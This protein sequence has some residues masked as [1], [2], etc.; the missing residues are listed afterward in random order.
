MLKMVISITYFSGQPNSEIQARNDKTI[1]VYSIEEIELIR[2]ASRIGRLA[3][4]AG[5]WAAKVG[6][7]TDYIDEVVH[8]VII[9]NDAYPSPLNYYN[10]PKSVCTSVNEVICHGIPD[11]RPLQDGDILNIDVSVYKGGVH[12]DL[13]ETFLIGNVAESAKHLV[14]NAYIALKKSIESCKP[15][16]MY[17]DIG[18]VISKHCNNESL[19]VVKSYCGHGVG[20]MFHCAPQVPHYAKNKAVGFMKP[21]HIFTIEPM[22]NQGDWR[23]TMWKD[24][25]TAVR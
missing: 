16:S 24:N 3:L 18:N 22:I 14:K 7:K 10:F 13:N 1:P 15:G 2:E 4:D 9:E 5:H 21:N 23:D 6:V 20:R 17:R 19:S 25:W 12:S 8:K 11:M